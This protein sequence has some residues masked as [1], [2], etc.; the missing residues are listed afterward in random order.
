MTVGLVLVSH[1]ASLA[2]GL[3][4][5]AAQ[6]APDVNIQAAG[7]DDDGGL[8][9]SF[10]KVEN[11]LATADSGHGVVVL[12]DLGSALLTTET[13]LELVGPQVA[14]MVRVIDAPLVEAAIEAA[15]AAQTGSDLA[16]VARAA[17]RAAGRWNQAG[18]PTGD[19]GAGDRETADHESDE[20]DAAGQSAAATGRLAAVAVVRNKQGLHARPAGKLVRELAAWGDTTVQIGRDPSDMADADSVLSLVALGLIEGDQVQVVAK[21]P[22]SKEAVDHVLAAFQDGFGELNGLS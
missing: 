1:S 6:M 15:I 11:A 20:T 18:D 12:Y 16:V 3:R 2:E 19:R 14:A 4:E 7:G 10:E 8:G 13:A 17:E 22:N 5:L 9:T 21:G